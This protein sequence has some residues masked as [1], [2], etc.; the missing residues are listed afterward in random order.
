M[1]IRAQQP[2]C[3]YSRGENNL[4]QERRGMKKIL[5]VVLTVGVFALATAGYAEKA[6]MGKSGEGL[7]KQHC[8]VCHPDGGN[9]INPQYT[10]NKKDLQ[11]H[12]IRKPGDIVRKMRHPGEGMTKFDKKTVS[13]KD[14]N[15]IAEY[16]LKTF[17]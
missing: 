14:A 8:A 6:D 13:D 7:F 16:I 4:Q 17:K 15:K 11:A 1:T 3:M 12:K 9:I 5:F 10:L 2:A